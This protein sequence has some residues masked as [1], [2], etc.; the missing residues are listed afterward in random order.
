MLW[1]TLIDNVKTALATNNLVVG[2][3]LFNTCT[4]FHVRIMLLPAMTHCLILIVW[5]TFSS[6]RPVHRSLIG[7][8]SG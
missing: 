6:G 7:D 8:L 3:N 4:Y 5:E 1:F 2:A